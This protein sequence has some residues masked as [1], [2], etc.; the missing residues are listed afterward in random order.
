M[1]KLPL[2][3]YDDPILRKKAL[4]IEEITPE[5]ER[6][7]ADMIETMVTS[8]GVGL[9]GP[10][11]GHLLRIFI[12]RDEVLGLDGQYKV[13][14]PEVIIN[15]TLSNPS[16]E[17][18]VMVE[19]CLSLPGLYLEVVRPKKIHVRYMNL[20]GEWVEEMLDEFRAR[21]T[22]HENDHLN[23]VL[24]IDRIDKQKRKKAEPHLLAI[25]K[26]YQN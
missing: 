23:G 10:Q 24:T 8:N 2:R 16:E 18:V 26:K 19:G 5:I 6:L 14:S 11:V 1:A 13:G 3:R 25:K 7:A 15:P 4:L 9:A 17:K 21:V 22:M 12:I 20:K